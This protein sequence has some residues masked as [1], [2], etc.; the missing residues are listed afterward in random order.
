LE[1]KV[2][3]WQLFFAAEDLQTRRLG[4]QGSEQLV[5]SEDEK[6]RHGESDL[7]SFAQAKTQY[8]TFRIEQ[9]QAENR[10]LKADRELR[11]LLG[12]E[13][14]APQ[15]FVAATEPL[16]DELAIDWQAA[17]AQAMNTRP[18]LAAQREAVRAAQLEEFRQANGL[19]PNVSLVADYAWSGLDDTLRGS[20]HELGTGDYADW[21][22]GI[23]YREP[24]GRR[25]EHAAARR[26]QLE[27]ARQRATLRNV[28]HEVLH[29]LT[30]A[31]QDLIAALDT[32]RLQQDRREAAQKQLDARQALYANGGQTTVDLLLRSQAALADALRDQA[33]AVAAYN[34]ALAR[35]EKAAGVV[36]MQ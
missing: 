28:Q 17:L 33:Q 9:L 21:G 2:A 7:G 34:Q 25:A 14:W 35:W 4:V 3:Y 10:L 6:L 36:V 11:R 30:D 19:R 20:S 31:Y 29:E 12:L 22:L 23:T 8:E 26:A 32:V 24:L 1:V 18:E 15:I 13:P 16:R 27:L 5:R